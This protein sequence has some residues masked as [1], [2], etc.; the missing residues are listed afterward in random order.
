MQAFKMNDLV[1]SRWKHTVKTFL[2]E[3]SHQTTDSTELASLSSRIVH[4]LVSEMNQAKFQRFWHETE[5]MT[6]GD[7]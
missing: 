3:F 2:P 5:C 7:M 6:I 4:K 1:Y